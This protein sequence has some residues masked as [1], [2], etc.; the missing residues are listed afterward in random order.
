MVHVAL[1]LR[2]EIL[3]QP[4][5]KGLNVC[6]EDAIACVPDSLYMFIRLMLGGKSL[7]ENGLC[8]VMTLT[9]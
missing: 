6:K 1:K 5:H 9:R 7:L 8:D 3:G 2:S 4:T